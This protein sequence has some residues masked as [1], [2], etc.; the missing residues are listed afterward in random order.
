[1]IIDDQS[2]LVGL[3]QAQKILELTERGENVVILSNH[4]TEADPQVYLDVFIDT[5]ID[6]W[7]QQYYLNCA[8]KYFQW[9]IWDNC[10]ILHVGIV[11]IVGKGRIEQIGRKTNLRR[12]SQ[13]HK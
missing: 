8:M 7:M 1:M 13:G 11:N 10:N 3:E 5:F 9:F 6:S 4:Q 12:W 2:R